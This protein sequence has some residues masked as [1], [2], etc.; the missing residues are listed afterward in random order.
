VTIPSS[1]RAVASAFEALFVVDDTAPF[2]CRRS[3]VSRAVAALLGVP[4]SPALG[5][6][7]TAIV[8]AAG[9]RAAIL[10]VP[11][12]VSVRARALDRGDAIARSLAL[13]KR[14]RT[15]PADPALLAEARRVVGNT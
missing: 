11:V 12:Y 5:Q 14:L 3:T 9:G 10:R 4:W 13:R 2:L 7:V 1:L 8:M 6:R 15:S